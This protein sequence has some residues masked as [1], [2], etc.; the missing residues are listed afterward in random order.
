MITY[1]KKYLL[2]YINKAIFTC[3]HL[4]Y[5]NKYKHKPLYKYIIPYISI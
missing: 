3:I 1:I 2:S 4:Q 5:I